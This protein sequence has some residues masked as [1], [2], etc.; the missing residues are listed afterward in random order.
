MEPDPNDGR[1]RPDTLRA[2]PRSG[3]SR[4]VLAIVG[5][6]LSVIMA[7]AI[8]MQEGGHLVARDHRGHLYFP[9]LRQMM[10]AHRKGSKAHTSGPAH[11]GPAP[12][13]SPGN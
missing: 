12:T 11:G 1:D 2:K 5:M 6:I 3:R 9:F 10:G 13:A 8:V 4:L 7:V